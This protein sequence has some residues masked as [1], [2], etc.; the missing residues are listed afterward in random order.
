MTSGNEK[1]RGGDAGEEP[2]CLHEGE[3]IL[4]EH[5]VCTDVDSG[6]SRSRKR[7]RVLGGGGEDWGEVVIS[8]LRKREEEL[9]RELLQQEGQEAR[10]SKEFCGLWP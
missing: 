6:R 9:C 10:V 3:T 7:E 8:Y 1:G 5:E 2:E 4:S